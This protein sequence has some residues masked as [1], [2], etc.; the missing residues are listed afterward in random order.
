M[1]IIDCLTYFI[2]IKVLKIYLLKTICYS[3]NYEWNN[4][5]WMKRDESV[6]D[7]TKPLLV[8]SHSD[9]CVLMGEGFISQTPSINILFDAPTQYF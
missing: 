6:R 4:I 2:K 7:C 3:Q 8:Q 1:T 5:R 9:T